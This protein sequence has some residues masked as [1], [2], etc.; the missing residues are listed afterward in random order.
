[1]GTLVRQSAA[2]LIPY[3]LPHLQN[4]M[5]R[6]PESY[7]EEFDK[8]YSRFDSMLQL[9]LLEPNQPINNDFAE[10]VQFLSAIANCYT[11][12]MI[13]GFPDAIEKVLQEHGQLL[14][15]DTRLSLCRVMITLRNKNLLEPLELHKLFFKMFMIQDKTLRDTLYNFIVNDIKSINV[16]HK[17]QTLN[18]R[19]QAYLFQILHQSD[20]KTTCKIAL[21]VLVELYKR[22]IWTDAKTVNVIASSCFNKFAG[23]VRAALNFFITSGA[24]AQDSDEEDDSDDDEDPLL[25]GP[26]AEQYIMRQI[27]ASSKN[28]KRVS[29]KKKK[30]AELLEKLRKKSKR[31]KK[32]DNGNFAAL[33]LIHD[34]QDFAEKLFKQM[35]K[36]KE[37]FDTKLLYLD[38]VAKLIGMHELF[39]LNFYPY[40]ERWLNPQQRN[41][42]KVLV[43]LAQASHDLIPPELLQQTIKVIANNFVTERNSSEVMAVGINSIREISNRCPLAMTEELLQDLAEYKKHK[44]KAVSAAAKSLI[45]AFRQHDRSMLAKK[46]QGRPDAD[47]TDT[48]PEYGADKTVDTIPGMEGEN[49]GQDGILDQDDF[50]KLKVKQLKRALKMKEAEDPKKQK[51]DSDGDDSNSEIDEI[52]VLKHDVKDE[53]SLLRQKFVK[54]DIMPDK[55]VL[56]VEGAKRDKSKQ[57]RVQSIHDG[58]EDKDQ[59]KTK[60]KIAAN[61]VGTGTNKQKSR[62]K[63]FTMVKHKINAKNSA[64]SYQEK[65]ERLREA[66]KKKQNRAHKNKF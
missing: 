24:S 56:F 25:N 59:Y 3:N 20:N 43:C 46:D 63:A 26:T 30:A 32:S 18:K 21:D 45:A 55:N 2:G 51:L 48:K 50:E 13:P 57:A 1:M 7:H 9:F 8:Q 60:N 65:A 41:V 42:S 4:M 5:K 40:C 61:Q 33:H 27:G 52:A 34:V 16:K 10:L 19:L 28:T 64:R 62:K 35:Q 14:H 17:N 44:Q 23:V 39:V 49:K 38:L 58:R 15:G 36:T 37:K 47:A 29:R 53:I 31:I 66:I 11:E 6:D 12:K 22:N 54:K